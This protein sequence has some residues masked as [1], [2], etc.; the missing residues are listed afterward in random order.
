MGLKNMMGLVWDRGYFHRTDLNQTI[1]ELAA[2]RR[3]DLTILDATRGIIDHGPGGPGTIREW[4]QVVFGVDPV[5][6]DVYGANLFGLDP[7]EI[8]HLTAAAKLGVGEM[9]T[10]EITV[11]KV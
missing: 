1:A 11:E 3:P 10:R 6:V 8:D 5:A 9:D 2:Y 4:N 7:A